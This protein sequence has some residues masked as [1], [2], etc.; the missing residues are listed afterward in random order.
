MYHGSIVSRWLASS[1]VVMLDTVPPDVEEGTV[2][3][4]SLSDDGTAGSVVPTEMNF[5]RCRGL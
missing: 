1:A 4:S 5:K 3:E 2:A